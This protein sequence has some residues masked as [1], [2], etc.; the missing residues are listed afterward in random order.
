MLAYNIINIVLLSYECLRIFPWMTVRSVCPLTWS[1]G[2]EVQVRHQKIVDH[3]QG[4]D[5][6]T[7]PWGNSC[8]C[9]A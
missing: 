1:S 6:T 4:H 8:S 5:F 3:G 7:V 9:V 2:I